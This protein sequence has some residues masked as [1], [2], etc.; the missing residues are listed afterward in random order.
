MDKHGAR[1]GSIF[2]KATGNPTSKNMQGQFHLDDIL[3]HPSSIIRQYNRPKYGNVTD[4]KIP[5][6]RGVRYSQ[7]GDFIMFL[8]P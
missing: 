3:T 8:E 5:G 4:I 6:N 2:P 7:T 1:P